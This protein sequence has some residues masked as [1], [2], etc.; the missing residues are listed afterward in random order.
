MPRRLVPD[1]LEH[2]RSCWNEFPKLALGAVMY[3]RQ[4]IVSMDQRFV[5]AVEQAF[6]RGDQNATAAAITATAQSSRGRRKKFTPEAIDKIK[7]LRKRGA[8]REDIAH[9]LGVSVN[10][11]SVTCSRLGISLRS[12]HDTADQDAR[13]KPA[14]DGIAQAREH[15]EVS[16]AAADT[17]PSGK[18]SLIIRCGDKE[19][20][21]DIPF[22]PRQVVALAVNAA[23][24]DARLTKLLAQLL[25]SAIKKDMIQ[26]IL[27][28]EKS[29]SAVH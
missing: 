19:I 6:R 22:T 12:E 8:R 23:L 10:S 28:S 29:P 26:Q 21:T 27:S 11:L 15:K 5:S 1:V 20:A 4:Q 25:V 17:T 7:E 13:T 9:S 16:Q 2:T 18:F 3:T 14:P 24:R